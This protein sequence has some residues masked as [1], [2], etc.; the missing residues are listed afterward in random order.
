MGFVI[1]LYHISE[2]SKCEQRVKEVEDCPAY[3][4]VRVDGR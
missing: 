1:E 2:R 3:A 4:A